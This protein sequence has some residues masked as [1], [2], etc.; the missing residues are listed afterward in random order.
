MFICK[1]T[2]V[3]TGHEHAHLFLQG[4]GKYRRQAAEPS[5][6]DIGIPTVVLF[7]LQVGIAKSVSPRKRIV[8]LDSLTS[9]VNILPFGTKE[10]RSA[11]AIR[12]DLEKKG[13]PIGPYDVLIAGTALSNKGTI[14]THNIKEFERVE[15][16]PLEDWY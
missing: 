10:V 14:V 5:T 7:E 2:H 13:T 12:A 16:L 4:C 1:F 3:Y 8:Q 15:G 11:A 9:V 6:S